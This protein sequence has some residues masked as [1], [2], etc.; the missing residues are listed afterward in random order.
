LPLPPEITD[1]LHVI[2]DGVCAE[3]AEGSSR[4]AAMS[5]MATGPDKGMACFTRTKCL[6]SQW[7]VGDPQVRTGGV[8][9]A[10]R[11]PRI[12]SRNVAEFMP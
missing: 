3:A 1:G 8:A 10:I 7:R 9:A 4:A 6:L 12:H 2:D 11:V 5:P